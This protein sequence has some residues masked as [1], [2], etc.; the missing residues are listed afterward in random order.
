MLRELAELADFAG[1]IAENA[2][3]ANDVY[4]PAEDLTRMRLF[5][6]W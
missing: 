5:F 3:T 1:G 2:F 6:I 4:S